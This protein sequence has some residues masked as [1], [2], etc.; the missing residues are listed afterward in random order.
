MDIFYLADHQEAVP[1]LAAWIYD[2][3]SFLYP[4]MTLRSVEDFLQERMNKDKLPLTLV[5]FEAAEPVG[6]VSLKR[7]DMESR[8]DLMY[9]LTSLYVAE[10]WRRK[11]IGSHLVK[12]AEKKAVELDIR[13]LFFFTIDDSLPGSF[14]SKLGWKKREKTKYHSCPVTI[15]EK[16]LRH[17]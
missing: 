17:P 5:A 3:W 14:Y 7:F 11:R 13:K 16:D 8:Q 4:E 2:E 9:W 10:P 12:S 1:I 6:T 15:M